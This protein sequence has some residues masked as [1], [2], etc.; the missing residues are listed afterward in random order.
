MFPLLRSLD[1]LADRRALAAVL[2]LVVGALL[3]AAGARLLVG[4]SP[5]GA[6]K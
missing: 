5:G 3:V 4:G 2:G 6:G 1:L